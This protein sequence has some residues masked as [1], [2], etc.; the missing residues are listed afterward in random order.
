M[1][2]AWDIYDCFLFVCQIVNAFDVRIGAGA[3]T[4]FISISQLDTDNNKYKM[5]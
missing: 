4:N 2:S 1:G 3:K 5:Q